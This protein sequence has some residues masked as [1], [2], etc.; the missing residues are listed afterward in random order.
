MHGELAVIL[1]DQKDEQVWNI[2]LI[3]I[4]KDQFAIFSLEQA[5]L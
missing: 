4:S 5:N 1:D 3:F 2:M